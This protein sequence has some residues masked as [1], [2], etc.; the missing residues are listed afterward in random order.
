MNGRE[1]RLAQNEAMFREIN[2]RLESH[3]QT[4]TDGEAELTVLCECVDPDCTDRIR[5]SPEAYAAV[6]EDGRQFLVRPRHQ[7]LDIEEV[8]ERND[9]YEVV[10]KRGV[11]GQVA[12]QLS[13]EP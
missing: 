11:A 12:E 2:E 10:R 8:V 3:I 1:A 13:D 5:I 9:E 7:C 6:R 4:F